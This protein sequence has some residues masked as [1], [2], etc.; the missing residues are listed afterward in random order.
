MVERPLRK[1]EALRE[2]QGITEEAPPAL[3]GED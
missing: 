3:K 2:S 1:I